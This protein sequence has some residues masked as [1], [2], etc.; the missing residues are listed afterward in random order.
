MWAGCSVIEA[1]WALQEVLSLIPSGL[2]SPEEISL[3]W[4][5]DPELVSLRDYLEKGSPLFHRKGGLDLRSGFE[6]KE[7]TFKEADSHLL[8]AVIIKNLV[9]FS[10]TTNCTE[11]LSKLFHLSASVTSSVNGQAYLWTL[12]E[13]SMN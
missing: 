13:C 11:A 6:N 12:L 9:K 1:T 8:W 3:S 2:E 10:S 4:H 5:T 7:Y